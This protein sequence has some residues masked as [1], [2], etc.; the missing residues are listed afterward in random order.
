MAEQQQRL[1]AFGV[2]IE[3]AAWPAPDDRGR[4]GLELDPGAQIAVARGLELGRLRDARAVFVPIDGA[5]LL[6]LDP[7]RGLGRPEPGQW[8]P[9]V[10]G[11]IVLAVVAMFAL[12][13]IAA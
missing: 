12:A 13:G 3:P 11:L 9:F 5:D 8:T 4:D 1:E 6:E 7:P 2:S 10:C